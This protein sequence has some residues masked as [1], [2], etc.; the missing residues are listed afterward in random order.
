M[1]RVIA[2]GLVLLTAGCNERSVGDL[3]SD[4]KV[5]TLAAEAKRI[6]GLDLPWDA[7][8]ALAVGLSPARGVILRAARVACVRYRKGG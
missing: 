7:A 5:A 6:C 8:Q 1:K 3:S 2:I 4:P